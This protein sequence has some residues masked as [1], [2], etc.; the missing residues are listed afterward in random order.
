[1]RV[2]FLGPPGAG[3]GTVAKL[4]SRRHALPHISTGDLLR[5][6]IRE[7]T[8][9]GK[10]AASYVEA[11]KLVP[12][13][14]VIE[15]MRERLLE[16][17]ASRGF[18]LDGFPR[19]E[20]QAQALGAML[21][22]E[23]MALDHAL[24][25]EV[26]DETILRRLA[27]R[28]TCERCGEIYHVTNIPPKREGRCDRCEGTLIQREDDKAETILKRLEVYRKETA[29]VIGYYGKEGLL[30]SVSGDLEVRDLEPILQKLL[31]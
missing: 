12:D 16:A 10:K 7:K 5:A 6:H 4:L 23:G 21:Q 14:L 25:F 13:D 1:M 18:I 17:D 11:G 24:N 28:R 8:G 19:T 9:L 29:P 20:G 22:E 15:M 2:V 3:K 31:V 26:T 30:R 27:G